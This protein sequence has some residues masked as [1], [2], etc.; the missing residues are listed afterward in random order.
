LQPFAGLPEHRICEYPAAPKQLA[1]DLTTNHLQ[2]DQNGEIPVPDAPG[3]G[4]L[5]NIAGLSRYLLD[6]EIVVQGATIYKTPKLE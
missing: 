3:H 4:M 6:V 1:V 2:P 5:V